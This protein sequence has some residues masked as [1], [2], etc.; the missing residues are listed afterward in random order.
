MVGIKLDVS[1]FERVE[2]MIRAFAYM[3][4]CVEFATPLTDD[5]L[6]REDVLVYLSGDKFNHT[7]GG[8]DVPVNFFT[9]S[10]RPAESR[11][12]LDDPPPL[13]VAVRIW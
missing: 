2:S 12:F 1:R 13:F 8:R 7:L 4:A 11:P 9:P 5:D 6:T 10:L 3:L